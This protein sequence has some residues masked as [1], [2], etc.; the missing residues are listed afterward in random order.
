[1]SDDGRRFP[2]GVEKK[3]APGERATAHVSLHKHVTLNGPVQLS[4]IVIPCDVIEDFDVLGA[5]LDGK[6][7]KLPLFEHEDGSRAMLGPD[8]TLTLEV[9]NRSD[10]PRTFRAAIFG[11]IPLTPEQLRRREE[12]A[13]KLEAERVEIATRYGFNPRALGPCCECDNKGCVAVVV[14]A[15]L[16]LAVMSSSTIHLCPVHFTP[17]RLRPLSHVAATAYKAAAFHLDS[18]AEA[19]ARA[20]GDDDEDD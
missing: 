2:I 5:Q 3:S 13:A 1:M 9:H 6:P 10:E 12:Q 16:G 4:N 14:T 19:E 7:L 15:S 18:V 20:E 17:G 11:T 8:Q